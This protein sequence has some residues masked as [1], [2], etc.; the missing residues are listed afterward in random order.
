[1]ILEEIFKTSVV[2]L[3][4]LIEITKYIFYCIFSRSLIELSRLSFRNAFPFDRYI[5]RC[6][7][8][9]AFV[10]KHSSQVNVIEL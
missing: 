5:L 1:M 9:L 6:F 3:Q 2:L 7:L 4:S 10:G 8:L